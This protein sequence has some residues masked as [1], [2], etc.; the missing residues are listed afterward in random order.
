MKVSSYENTEN[1][2][3]NIQHSILGLDMLKIFLFTVLL[4]I[5]WQNTLS[6]VLCGHPKI[7]KQRGKTLVSPLTHIYRIKFLKEKKNKV[8]LTSS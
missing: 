3:L 7:T 8:N 4:G 1:N 2:T 5:F 6:P